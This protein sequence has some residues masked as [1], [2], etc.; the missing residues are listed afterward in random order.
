MTTQNNPFYAPKSEAAEF[1]VLEPGSY[2]GVCIGVTLKEF[3]NFN[4]RSKMDEKVQFV[5]Q[6]CEGGQQYYLRSKPCKVVLNEKSN[7]YLLIN[8]WTKA[9]LERIADGF[10]C[11][12]MVG[13]GAQIIVNQREYNGKTYADIANVLPLKKGVKVPVTPAEI[14]AFLDAN[15]KASIWAGGITVKAPDLTPAGL[16]QVNAGVYQKDAGM[17][18][19]LKS[20]QQDASNGFVGGVDF[21]TVTPQP[22]PAPAVPPQEQAPQVDED[23]DLPFD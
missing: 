23:E 12:K 16:K 14:P 17:D 1:E 7:L 3:P 13:F 21:G 4:D 6:I 15:T 20:E 18:V 10:S 9:S 22:A 2:N 8:G 11:D 5:F 19:Q